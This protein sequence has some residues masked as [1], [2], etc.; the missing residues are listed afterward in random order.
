[1]GGGLPCEANGKEKVSITTMARKLDRK[2]ITWK[3][4]P[5]FVLAFVVPIAG[6]ETVSSLWYDIQVASRCPSK[7]NLER[8]KQRRKEWLDAVSVMNQTHSFVFMEVWGWGAEEPKIYRTQP[9]DRYRCRYRYGTSK[10]PGPFQ[11][12]DLKITAESKRREGPRMSV[13]SK[14]EPQNKQLRV[15]CG[16]STAIQYRRISTL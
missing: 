14:M 8:T 3:V 9:G 10:L 7:R 15:Q 12:F 5:T 11:N 1:M 6:A 13:G 4:F 16:K 2:L